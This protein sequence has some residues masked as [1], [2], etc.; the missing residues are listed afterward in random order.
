MKKHSD[1]FEGYGKFPGTVSQEIDEK[2]IPSIQQPRWI[3]IALRS[4]L[5]EELEKLQREG[6]TVKETIHT[7]WV[8]NIGLVRRGK[9]T[10]SIRITLD[11][12]PLNKALKRPIFSSIPLMSFYPCFFLLHFA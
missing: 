7:V 12:T 5:R 11:P 9:G 1:I 4:K 3:P 8:S 10:D 2:V 6:V